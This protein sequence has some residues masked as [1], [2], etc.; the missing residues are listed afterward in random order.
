MS[1]I[2]NAGDE[3]YAGVGEVVAEEERAKAVKE[4]R[5]SPEGRVEG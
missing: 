4:V 3:F 2:A 1:D 5:T